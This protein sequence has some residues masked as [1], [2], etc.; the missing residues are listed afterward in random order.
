MVNL[1]EIRSK[2]PATRS[3]L[4]RLDADEKRFY[5]DEGLRVRTG[6]EI[7]E[8]PREI[9]ALAAIVGG[10]NLLGE[11]NF[12]IVWGWSRLTII[13]GEWDDLDAS[14][15]WVRTV[16]EYRWEPKNMPFNRFHLERWFGPECFGPKDH[17][18]EITEEEFN[19]V[20]FAALGPFPS[21]GEYEACFCFENPDGTYQELQ[22]HV[23]ETV[24]Q[25]FQY[26]RAI[27][28]LE[29]KKGLQDRED[30]KKK[31]DDDFAYDLVKDAEP[32]WQGLTTV[33]V[34]KQIERNGDE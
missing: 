3:L 27:T 21:R 7:K 1:P 26:Q 17:W 13:A 4:H 10:L 14:G 12:R 29:R 9:Q 15:N 16:G 28:A 6:R 5:D 11:P 19:G 31:A 2:D 18:Y 34:N 32:A 20:K 8:V 23:V 33:G 22:A 25:A 24:I 30:R